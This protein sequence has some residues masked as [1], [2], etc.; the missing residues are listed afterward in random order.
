LEWDGQYL[1]GGNMFWRKKINAVDVAEIHN[2]LGLMSQRIDATE[3]SIR[4][5]RGLINRK[6]EYQEMPK[7]KRVASQDPLEELSPEERA[8]IDGLNPQEKAQVMEKIK[9][10]PDFE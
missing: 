8:F 6:I 2:V 7:A 1:S 3:T 5:L 9:N 4:S 10:N